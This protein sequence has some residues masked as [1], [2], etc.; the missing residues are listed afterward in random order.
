MRSLDLA[1]RRD[2]RPLLVVALGAHCDDV[3]IGAGGLLQLLAATCPGTRFQ[4]TVLSSVPDRAAEARASLA[5][6]TAGGELDLQVGDLP[7]GRLPGCWDAAKDA[8]Q[9]AGARARAAGGADLVLAPWRG[10][11]HQDHRLLAELTPTVFRDE[12]VLGYEIAKWDGDLGRPAVH[13]PLPDALA[14]RKSALLHEHY[15]SQRDRDWFDRDT[16][17][18]LLRLRG[19]E[20]RARYAEAFHL[21]KAVLGLPSPGGAP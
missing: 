18:G 4:V 9:A 15:A 16:F 14:E 8:V 21:D 1:P 7:D 12:L 5:A 19:V 10:D 3:E 11:R 6:F 20:C 17:L 2:G 13:V